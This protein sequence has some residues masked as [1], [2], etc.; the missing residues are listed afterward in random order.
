MYSD[1]QKSWEEKKVSLIR[2]LHSL[3]QWILKPSLVLRIRAIPGWPGGFHE[4]S[5]T[6]FTVCSL[7]MTY[8]TLVCLWG[9]WKPFALIPTGNRWVCA[10]CCH[11]ALFYSTQDL[12]LIFSF[13]PSSQFLLPPLFLLLL[14]LLLSFLFL[15]LC[16][17][18]QTVFQIHEINYFTKCLHLMMSCQR[19]NNQLWMMCYLPIVII[20]FYFN[21]M[22]QR[23]L[24]LLHYSKLPVITNG[25]FL[26]GHIVLFSV[27]KY[28]YCHKTSANLCQSS[29]KQLF[30]H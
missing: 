2:E 3:R 30:H 1:L 27:Y 28:I 19:R 10:E 23:V 21:S 16:T 6:W 4:A 22:L 9:W 5:A 20:S 24:F 8:C 25:L 7:D 17:N 13:F 15:Y 14:L 26:N 11:C 12:C 29:Y 18:F